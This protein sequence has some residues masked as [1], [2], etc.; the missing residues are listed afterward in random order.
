MFDQCWNTVYPV[1]SSHTNNNMNKI[2]ALQRILP[3]R[4]T[5]LSYVN[6]FDRLHYLGLESLE[7]RRLTYD[8]VMCFEIC[9]GDTDIEVNSLFMFQCNTVTRGHIYKLSKQPARVNA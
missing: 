7:L 9:H 2:E 8:L 6:Y 4:I 5:D 3:K 1:W